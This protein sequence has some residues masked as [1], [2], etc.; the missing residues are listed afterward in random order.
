[1]DTR[2]GPAVALG[3]VR[4]A[5]RLVPARARAAWRAEWEG[6]IWA[7]WDQLASTSRLGPW[8][9]LDLLMRATGSLVDALTYRDGRWTMGGFGQEVGTAMRGLVRRPAFSAVVVATLTVAI[10]ASTAIFGVARD[11]L[12][13]PF[14]YPSPDR[15]VAVEDIHLE[16]SVFSSVAY[17]NIADLDAAATSFEAIGAARWWT[18]VLEGD[19][20]AWVVRGATVTANF[21]D[22]LGTDAGE[23]RF[24]RPDEEGEGRDAQ[25]VLAHQLWVERFG[26]DPDL[27][28]RK[29]RLS[30]TSYTVIGI[31]AA[32][33][34][35]PWIM[36]G[37]GA[38]PQVWR[39]VAS[40]PSEWPRSGR[41]WRGIAR[42]RPEV[43]L[44]AAQEE[45]DAIFAGL[46]E[47]FPEANANRRV[48]IT[49]LRELVAGPAEPV[50]YVLLASVGLLL[51]I[52]CTNLA[53]LLIGRA[54]DRTREIAVHRALGAPGWRIVGRSVA[55]TGLL[56]VA[57]GV[58]G[59]ALAAWLGRLGV[60]L[61]PMLPRPVTGAVDGLVLTFA[62]LVTVGAAVVCG[63]GP[64]VHAAGG[65]EIPG[66]DL[67]RGSSPAQTAQRL[68]RLLV[69]GQLAL[70]TALLIGAGLLGRS[71]Q[72][73]QAVDLGLRTDGVVG[74]ALHGEAWSGLTPQAAQAKW[75][76]LLA[77]VRSQPE[78]SAAGA[79]DYVPLGGDYSCDGIERQDQPPPAPGEGRCAEVR[80]VLLGALETMEIPL[81]RG[82]FF[83]DRDGLDQPPTVVIDETM[84]RAFWPGEDPL[85]ARISVHTRVHEVVGV[86]GTMLHFGPGAPARPMLY[87]HAPQEG[88]NGVA[89]GLSV[90]ARG[91]DEE[92]V[93][94][95][96]RRGVSAVDPSIAL[97]EPQPFSDLL[98][99]SLA[100]PRFRTYLMVAFG[101]TALFLSVL[102]IAG[103]MAY[104]VA[105]RRRELGIRLALGAR[106]DE[107]LGLVLR[108]GGGLAAVGAAIGLAGALTIAGAIEALLFDV[109]ARDPQVYAGAV[110]LILL[111]AAVAC[112]LPARRASRVDPVEALTAE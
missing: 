18:P 73:L 109:G 94:D 36:D 25:V 39:T 60:A 44:E 34:E 46:V 41:S 64:A 100:A 91:S 77:A 40:E 6:E 56:V 1:M 70:S 53:N 101:S 105:R 98:A 97:A 14:P 112:Y 21:F 33:F 78:V 111:S 23:G 27:V 69:V 89:R 108:E 90:V 99:R 3:I 50:L 11:V 67:A 86:A 106:A 2:R 54:L 63:L 12:L 19:D 43:S 16:R 4:A 81:L 71:L 79:I 107:V 5:G 72:R 85:G 9:R 10:G 61:S 110:V 42:I 92:A 30:G 55:E 52:A 57:G 48:R 68:R 51:L 102:G 82:R 103:L 45:L 80:V 47:A 49:P 29:V 83:D 22:I 76:A 20:G 28:G 26:A 37:P 87:L 38:E 13:R 62:V 7:R 93:A 24:F 95:A 59:V 66:L 84:A 74:V 8:T 75:D 96:V 35:D 104:S 65:K 17:P 58:G 15:V 88:W 31:T 32:E